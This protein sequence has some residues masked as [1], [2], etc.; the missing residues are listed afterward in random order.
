MPTNPQCT[1]Y[2]FNKT[3][4]ISFNNQDK[5]IMLNKSL[6][7]SYEYPFRFGLIPKDNSDFIEYIDI[8]TLKNISEYNKYLNIDVFG[9]FTCNQGENFGSSP[10][11]KWTY[12]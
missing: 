11:N 2:S 10:I 4:N 5:S 6:H 7:A 3:T 9:M 1:A 12:L 8:K